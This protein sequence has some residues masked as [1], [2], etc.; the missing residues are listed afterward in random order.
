MY[1]ARIIVTY[2]AITCCISAGAAF[3]SMG[4]VISSFRLSGMAEPFAT[5]VYAGTSYVYAIFYSASDNYL[6]RYTRA[7]SLTSTYSLRGSR[8]PRGGDGCHLGAGYLS[9]VDSQTNRLL[10]YRTNGGMPVAS[11]P[12]TPPVGY[13][14]Q[15]VM[16]TGS[17]YEVTD[18]VARGSFNRYAGDGT[19]EGLVTYQ[20]WPAAMTGTGAA[21]YAATANGR[22]GDYLVASARLNGQPSCILDVGGAGS[23]V[24]TFGMPALY[25]CGGCIGPSSQPATYGNAYWV[26]WVVPSSIYCM[27]VDIGGRALSDVAPASLG[28]VKALYR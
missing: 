26:S 18:G 1:I 23:L 12:V 20:G 11:F 7:G 17:C 21:A 28:K 10:M 13:S 9:V 4:S 14:L 24:A 5:G 25:A 27:Q 2:W 22:N 3:A 6:Y 16:W 15:D 8:V 19:F